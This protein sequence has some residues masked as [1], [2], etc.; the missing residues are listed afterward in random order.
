MGGT[1]KNNAKTKLATEWG[2]QLEGVQ[3]STEDGITKLNDA[4]TLK[5]NYLYNLAK[6]G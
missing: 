5:Q 2:K 3:F 4:V 1:K 6:L